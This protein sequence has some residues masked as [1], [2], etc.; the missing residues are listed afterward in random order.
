MSVNRRLKVMAL[1]LVVPFSYIMSASS[2]ENNNQ[3]SLI[4]YE[5]EVK[6]PYEDKDIILYN[7][8]AR[9]NMKAENRT[10][11]PY[12]LSY[13]GQKAFRISEHTLILISLL[14]GITVH[15]SLN[16]ECKIL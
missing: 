15:V 4:V 9:Y 11:V 12:P 13:F 16:V 14:Y 6:H 7:F 2:K 8:L 3:D 10:E 1:L 5:H